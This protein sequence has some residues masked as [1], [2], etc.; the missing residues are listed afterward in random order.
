MTG[1]SRTEA[2]GGLLR[3]PDFRRLWTA[4]ALSQ[5]GSRISVLAVPLVA[6]TTLN[7]SAFEVSLL[8]TLGM[9]P[10]LLFVLQAGAWC[11]RMR[12]LP[13]L[14]AADLGCAVVFGSVPIAAAFGVLTIWWLLAAVTVAGLFS[15]FFD[16]SYQ[17][18]LPRLLRREDV[19]EGNAKLQTNLSVAAV[20]GPGA[21][22]LLIQAF[23]GPVAILA[24]ALSFLWSAL[25]L[26]RIRVVEPRPAPVAQP[27]LRREIAEGLRLVAGQ[28]ILR[29][30]ALSGTMAG[31][32]QSIQMA[33]SV[34]FLSREVHLSPGVIGLLSTTTLLGAVLGAMS[35]RRLGARFGPARTLWVSGLLCGVS[36]LLFPLTGSGIALGFYVAAGFGASFTI[37]VLNVH[38]TS[39]QQQVTPEGL[40][41]RVNATMRFL[42]F[43]VIPLGSL[44]GGGLATTIGLRAALWVS[45]VGMVGMGL[46]LVFSPLRRLRD[47]PD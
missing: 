1:E 18:Y 37:I 28:P 5:L 14:I 34:V 41:G 8:R 27:H 44:L 25:W 39:F 2:R 3:D 43:G 22:G 15:V 7:A 31:I 46:C 20:A 47:L 24:D 10:Y 19:V 23:G 12:A 13:V 4:D 26:R 6:V 21:A 29:A 33:V 9:L 35:A 36:F 45:G 32:F 30:I 17:T 16:V 40:R 42:H 11:D 38:S